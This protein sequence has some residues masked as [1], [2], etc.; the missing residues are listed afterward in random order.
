VAAPV[1]APVTEPDAAERVNSVIE[2]NGD[3]IFSEQMS[4]LDVKESERTQVKD[5][6]GGAG[7]GDKQ[8]LKVELD[9]ARFTIKNLNNGLTILSSELDDA[10]AE[11]DDAR[12]ELVD[13]RAELVDARAELVDARAELDRARAD[14]KGIIRERDELLAELESHW[15]DYDT[16]DYDTED[17]DTDDWKVDESH[18]DVDNSETPLAGETLAAH[19]YSDDSSASSTD[20]METDAVAALLALRSGYPRLPSD[21]PSPPPVSC[22]WTSAFECVVEEVTLEGTTTTDH[23]DRMKPSTIQRLWRQAVHSRW[24]YRMACTLD[25]N[26]QVPIIMTPWINHGHQVWVPWRVV[27][28]DHQTL[29]VGGYAQLTDKGGLYFSIQ[30]LDD[31]PEVIWH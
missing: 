12:A 13:A 9:V 8:L 31:G 30:F 3:G 23:L 27:S 29:T 14:L 5:L 11:L 25:V 10:R 1:A 2:S 15:S 28:F 22:E 17:Y 18:E 6:A 26:S 19:L 20:G 24:L 21:Q 4:A 16:E 7:A